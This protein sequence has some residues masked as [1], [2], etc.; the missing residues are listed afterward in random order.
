MAHLK[1]NRHLR[2]AAVIVMG[3]LAGCAGGSDASPIRISGSS[4]VEP[5]TQAIAAQGDFTVEIAAEGTTDGFSQF[6]AGETA[7][8][9]AS[10]PI[11]GQGHAVN[12][13]QLCADNDV[14]FIELPIALDALSIIR[15]EAA[16]F[17]TDITLDELRAVWAPDSEV[18]TWADVRDG[19]PADEIGLYGRGEGS[20]TFEVFTRV[21]SGETGAIR[22]DYRNTDD[23]QGFAA[24]IAD[25]E[26]GLGFMGIGNYLAADE[27][28]RDRITNVAVDG[29]EPSLDEVQDGNYAA[30]TRPLFIYVA[31]DALEDENVTT[32]VDYYL[33]EVSD[34][35]PRVFFY[36]LPDEAYPLVQQRFDERT[37]GSLYGEGVSEAALVLE[38]LSSP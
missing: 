14:E 1:A 28:S 16:D 8:N 5:I 9:N 10:T 20:G 38:L 19:W 3:T 27:E 35:L 2:V 31:V 37:T 34:L 7:I 30:L 13:V 32:F 36:A 26:N 18:S 24:W 25:D 17:V 15:N 21:V 11:P 23:L 22:D 12:Y 6:C 33:D 4:T 29:V